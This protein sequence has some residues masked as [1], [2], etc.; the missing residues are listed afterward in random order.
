[1][2]PKIFEMERMQSVWENR[3]RYNLSES[4]VLP[5][6]LDEMLELSELRGAR[7]GYSQTN[8]SEQLRGLISAL[9][10]G[11]DPNQILVTNGTAEANPIS[12]CSAAHDDRAGCAGRS[13]WSTR[14]ATRTI[15][16]RFSSERAGSCRFN[17]PIVQDWVEDHAG[18][19]RMTAPRAGAIA[20]YDLAL[21]S[22]VLIER[23][24]DEKSVLGP[25]R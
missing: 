12:V 3:V 19:L 24:R 15:A 7:L 21:N 13:P 22:T 10:P 9:C 16:P 1:M 20:Y 4:G 5:L 8:G 18:C 11:S 17:S 14:A 2:R 25:A 6:E 23:L